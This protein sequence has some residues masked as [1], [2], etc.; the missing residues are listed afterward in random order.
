VYGLAHRAGKL[1]PALTGRISCLVTAALSG[2][3]GLV[4]GAITIPLME[5]GV[6]SLAGAVTGMFRR[7]KAA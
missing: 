2:V 1:L 7:K 4:V 6:A 3:L 5:Y